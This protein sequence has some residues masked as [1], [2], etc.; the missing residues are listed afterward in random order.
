MKILMKPTA[1]GTEFPLAGYTRALSGISHRIHAGLFLDTFSASRTS[2]AASSAMYPADV[3][4]LTT[5]AEYNNISSNRTEFN[6]FFS[7][8]DY[9]E[10]DW[11]LN[12]ALIQ[13]MDDTPAVQAPLFSDAFS[14]DLFI[15]YAQYGAKYGKIPI[16]TTNLTTDGVNQFNTMGVTWPQ[17]DIVKLN[18]GIVKYAYFVSYKGT[19][20]PEARCFV[21]RLDV[22]DVMGTN[23]HSTNYEIIL[24]DVNTAN[25]TSLRIKSFNAKVK[26]QVKNI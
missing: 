3:G 12:P 17:S 16:Y 23:T 6:V 26:Y 5:P 21:A 4:G 25:V 9:S 24:N 2:Y 22:N 18:E 7:E 8:E 19:T 20:S 10:S 11:F 13:Q 1:A 15:G 14:S